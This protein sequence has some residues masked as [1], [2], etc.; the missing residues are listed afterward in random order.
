[1]SASMIR[2]GLE[3]LSDDI[4]AVSGNKKQKA[5]KKQPVNQ[6]G[7]RGGGGVMDQI[8]SNRQGVTK[9]VRRLQG[10]LGSGKSKA[11]VKDKRIRSAVDEFRKKQK[12]SQLSKNLSYFMGLGYKA[13]QSDTQKILLQNKGRQSR[14][15]PDPPVKKQREQRSLFT[16]EQFQQFQKEYFGRTVEDGR[17]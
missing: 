15:R 12:S 7:G 11:T 8:S 9:Q 4:K 10:R 6:A 17:K 3:L 1:M 5:R 13:E 14:N 2:R 16:E